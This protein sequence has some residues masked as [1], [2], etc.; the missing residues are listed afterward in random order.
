MARSSADIALRPGFNVIPINAQEVYL[1]DRAGN[2]IHLESAATNLPKLCA[3]LAHGMPLAEVAGHFANDRSGGS[4]ASQ[5]FVDK[6]RSLGVLLREAAPGTL[7]AEE[8]ERFASEIGYFGRFEDETSSRFEYLQRLRDS[9][10]LLLGLGGV[11]SAVLP[12]LVCCGIGKITAVDMDTV[13][14]SNLGRQTFYSEADVGR[15][16]I[17][18]AADAVKRLSRFTKFEGIDK[19]I[20][21]SQDIREIL[22]RVGSAELMIQAADFPIWGVTVWAAQASCSTGVPLL[23]SSYMGVG[24]LTLPGKSACPAC[25]LPQ[26]VMQVPNAVNLVSFQRDLDREHA[27]G[28]VLTTSVGHY[29]L[30]IAHEAISFLTGAGPLRTL[31]AQLRLSLRTETSTV[32][33]ELGQNPRCPVC[34]PEGDRDLLPF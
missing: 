6:L 2:S 25:I 24:P 3:A 7:S 16:K 26:A 1:Y 30:H 5:Q 27:P 18:A 8:Q 12:H 15:K 10:V 9:H 11:G 19:K 22:D 34:G 31:N 4:V 33:E 28:P 17:V 14:T 21:S 29:G 20:S 13:E 23:P 32:R